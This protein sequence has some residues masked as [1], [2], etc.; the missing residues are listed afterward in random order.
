MAPLDLNLHEDEVRRVL[1]LWDVGGLVGLPGERGG[2]AN[3]AVVVDTPA[4]RF[5]LKRRNPRYSAP[6]MLR[7]DHALMEHLARKGLCT[8]LAAPTREGPRWAVVE[9]Q[10]YELYPYLPGA[11]HDPESEAQ[12]RE[13]GGKLA[14]F[15]AAAGDFHA[16]PGK[17]WPRYH[18]PA[19]SVAGLEW[20]EALVRDQ[21]GPTPG[22]RERDEALREVTELLSLVRGLAQD[23]PD[24]AYWGARVVMVHGDWHPGNVKYEGDRI[25]GIF[26]LDWATR[27]PLLVDLADGVMYFAGRRPGGLD[28]T[29]IRTLTRAFVLD[30]DRTRV[31]LEGYRATGTLGTEEIAALPR[32]LLARWLYSRVDPMRRKIPPTEAIDYL[33][34]GIW[35]PVEAIRRLA[36]ATVWDPET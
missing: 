35:G 5:F 30:A 18:D 14:E 1:P 2:T 32:F 21:S 36:S 22:G 13:A 7:H 16:P 9:G 25:S 34:A 26:D 6:E 29:D 8:P 3:P 10:V 19:N 23:F 20:A 33:L 31:F 15:H 28:A 11:A 17:G 12:L 24:A 4:G 27:Q